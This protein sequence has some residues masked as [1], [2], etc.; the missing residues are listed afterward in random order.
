MNEHN[1]QTGIE[2]ES[3]VTAGPTVENEPPNG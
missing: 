1:E 2:V 3:A